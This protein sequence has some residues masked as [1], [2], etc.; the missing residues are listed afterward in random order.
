MSINTRSPKTRGIA[1]PVVIVIVLVLLTLILAL[2]LQSRNTGN[3]QKTAEKQAQ[4]ANTAQVIRGKMQEIF[5]S[6]KT[7]SPAR[8]KELGLSALPPVP[9]KPPVAFKGKAGDVEFSGSFNGGS[10]PWSTYNPVPTAIDPKGFG[11]KGP[12]SPGFD[13]EKLP[14]PP[15]H[16]LLFVNVK[17]EAGTTPTTYYYMFSNNSPYGIIAPGGNIKI[18]KGSAIAVSEQAPSAKPDKT[19]SQDF[20]LYA[21]NKIEVGKKL[22]GTA[23]TQ[24][25]TKDAVV[26]GDV[27]A[28][29][30]REDEPPITPEELE[31]IA[32]ALKDA[33]S[34]MENNSKD[35]GF[36][37]MAMALMS[38]A[39]LF[40]GAYQMVDTKGFGFDGK[41]LIWAN[42]MRIPEKMTAVCPFPLK[43]REDLLILKNSVFI[44]AGDLKVEGS[45]FI[46][47]NSGLLVLGKLEVKDRV[48]VTYKVDDYLGICSAII[49]EKDIILKKGVRHLNFQP[50]GEGLGF[51]FSGMICPFPEY[52][53]VGGKKIPNPVA[54]AFKKMRDKL[55]GK[56]KGA[57]AVLTMFACDKVKIPTGTV[58]NDLPGILIASPKGG[59]KIMDNGNDACLAGLIV[60]KKGIVIEFPPD[61]SGVFTGILLSWDENVEMF[62]VEYRY[63]PYSSAAVI[64]TGTSG[65]RTLLVM[66][67]PHLVSSGEYKK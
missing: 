57:A 26:L 39:V 36:K 45:L 1:L 25:K 55:L 4:Q 33:M 37:Q 38:A 63:Y 48:Y 27:T 22:E 61:G 16:S 13:S 14:I 8:L 42:S 65:G 11:Y 34:E 21:K 50:Q 40:H 29:Q 51:L 28:G 2:V 20:F 30:V 6:G 43:I 47:E 46:P 35:P 24:A 59:V 66:P 56:L 5:E 44:V 12:Q 64:P 19:A 54:L 32:K 52:I 31:A 15:N 58:N 3:L 62:N 49:A 7:P 17:T 67:Q 9:G 18:T 10:E 23:I 41:Q 60:C 53:K